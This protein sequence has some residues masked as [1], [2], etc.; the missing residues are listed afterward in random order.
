MDQVSNGRC[1]LQQKFFETFD[2]LVQHSEILQSIMNRSPDALL[3]EVLQADPNLLVGLVRLFDL[4][5]AI[6]SMEEQAG[7]TRPLQ[8]VDHKD[9]ELQCTEKPPQN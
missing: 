5:T 9:R 2:L 4:R 7:M 1:F 3:T 8:I 6:R